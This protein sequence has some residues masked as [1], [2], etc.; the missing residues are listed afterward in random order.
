[1]ISSFPKQAFDIFREHF[2]LTVKD[3]G[4]YN[5]FRCGPMKVSIDWCYAQ[6]LGNVCALRASA[7]LGLMKMNT[8]VIHPMEKD[9]PLFSFD[10]ISAMG[11]HT[12]LLEIYDTMQGENEQ[13]T[14]SL[15]KLFAIKSSLS[16]LADYNL[17][18]H[19]YDDIK[20]TPSL[21][22]RTKKAHI[23]QL[24]QSATDFLRI[25][26]ALCATAQPAVEGNTKVSDYVNGLFE[27]G[28]PST[29]TFKKALGEEKA[30]Q[31]FEQIIFNTI[32]SYQ[33]S[34]R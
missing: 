10:Y 27:N 1:M 15:S 17:G 16:E 6:G 9:A 7:P 18:Q 30:R 4:A 28:G 25:Y 26:V 33:K 32:T 23:S 14:D 22:K 13:L 34:T 31:L 11:N 29:D 12:L 5:S 19:W 8:L 3:A 24:E 2:P 20:M 21:A